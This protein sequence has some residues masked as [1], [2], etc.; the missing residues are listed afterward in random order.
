MSLL[1][2]NN[3]KPVTKEYLIWNNWALSNPSTY[4]LQ[5]KHTYTSMNMFVE[6]K[7]M[8]VGKAVIEFNNSGNILHITPFLVV[9]NPIYGGVNLGYIDKDAIHIENVDINTLSLALCAD[10]IREQ[11]KSYEF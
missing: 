6:E 4:E 3:H 2:V 9:D 5:F 1:D 7:T 11:F 10:H 8:I